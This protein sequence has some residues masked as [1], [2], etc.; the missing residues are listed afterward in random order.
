MS[1]IILFDIDHTLLDTGKL[2]KLFDYE[3][4]KT[5]KIKEEDLERFN[6]EFFRRL[7]S[8][9]EFSPR[10]Y[11]RFLEKRVPCHS[12]KPTLL[13]LFFKSNVYYR[14]SLYFDTIPVLG[15]LR[16]KFSLGVFSEG[17]REFQLTKL[18]L[19]G[20]VD[21]LDKKIVFIYPNKKGKAGNLV[22]RLGSFYVVDDNPEHILALAKVRGVSPILIKRETRD[23][24]NQS[25]NFKLISS[26]SEI[27]EKLL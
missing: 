3:I 25:S 14:K 7:R 10:L 19:S 17:V 12:L 23:L 20:L 8:S 22:E 5:L 21:Y 15:K 1:S 4:C 27:C 6:Q 24:E 26:L 18:K 16:R 2:K 13:G 11:I 9:I